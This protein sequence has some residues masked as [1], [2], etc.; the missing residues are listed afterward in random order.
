V[1]RRQNRVGYSLKIDKERR[2]VTVS[3]WGVLDKE[4]VLAFR[5]ELLADE[6]FKPEF[7]QLIEYNPD[8]KLAL[9]SQEVDELKFSDPFSPVSR[10]AAVAHSDVLFGYARMYA[11]LMEARG[12]EKIR[13]FRTRAEAVL[14]IEAE[15]AAGSQ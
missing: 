10:R 7:N 13:A 15:Q 6:D 11:S 3:V 12:Q 2:L 8:T 9:S 1:N 14:W 4:S 5:R